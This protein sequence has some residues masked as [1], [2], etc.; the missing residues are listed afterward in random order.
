MSLRILLCLLLSTA[1]LANYQFMGNATGWQPTGRGAIIKSESGTELHL[2]FITHEILR[3]TLVR[4]DHNEALLT[5]A[6][7]V[8]PLSLSGA[9]PLRIDT[10]VTANEYGLRSASLVVTI[11]RSPL[12]VTVQNREGK[13]LLRDDSTMA[14]GWDGN[15]VRTW[16]QI[17]PG[18]KFFGQG[19]KGGGLDKRGRELQ[20]W[21]SDVPAYADNSDPL[22]QSVPFY[23]GLRDSLAYGVYFNNSYRSKFNFGAGQQRYTSFSSEGGALDYFVFNGPSIA[24]VVRRFTELTGKMN[25][26]PLWALGYQQSRWSYFPDTEVTRLAQTFRDKD[27]PCDVIY[28]DIHYM[29]GYRVFTWDSTRFPQ[30]KKMLADLSNDGFKI[31]PIIDP[32]VKADSNYVMAKEGLAE[33]HF[34]KY[35]DGTT[36]IGEVWPGQSYFPDFSNSKTRIWWGKHVAEFRKQGVRGFWNDMNEPACWGQAFPLETIFDDSGRNSS[37]KKMHNLYALQMAQATYEG[38][39]ASNSTERPFILTRAGFAGTQRYSAAWTG[40]NV[41]S[42]DHLELG[43]RMMLGLGLSGQPFIGTDIGGFIGTASPELYARWV[44]VGVFSPFCRSHTH[45]GSNDKEPWSFGENI[46]EINRKFIRLR[47]ALLPYLYTLF[48]KSSQTG[49]PII[50]PLF[51]DYQND[52][53][54][55]DWNYQQQFFVGQNILLAPVTHE[56]QYTKKL[57]LPAGEWLDWNTDRVYSGNQEIIVDAHLDWLPI[58]LKNGSLVI[59]RDVQD[60]TGERPVRELTLDIFAVAGT[61][62]GN[63]S[64]FVL[65]EDDGASFDYQNG[66]YRN[67]NYVHEIIGDTL[68]LNRTVTVDKYKVPDRKLVLRW[69]NADAPESILLNGASLDKFAERVTYDAIRRILEVRLDSELK[70]KSLSV[71]TKA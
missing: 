17:V 10:S 3:V 51:Y 6:F 41:A 59:K 46:E 43:I 33:N 12:R 39:R 32:G 71:H 53:K 19:L 9:S 31:T 52:L 48:Q 7:A 67:T 8:D 1:A 36:H 26:P 24:H 23:I 2:T 4:K 20:M 28:L 62:A 18:E 34:V 21:N 57:Y 69:H 11:A 25:L 61:D 37:H 45:Y 14:Y 27:I 15:E 42:E 63:R 66:I 47:Y 30:P 56:K 16:K 5:D 50:R 13:V 22:Y 60:Y 35:P 29:D 65:Y 44:Q 54:C 70:L 64:S 58:F 38:L 40:D 49:E 68:L 55:F